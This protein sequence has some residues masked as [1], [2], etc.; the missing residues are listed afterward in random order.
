MSEDALQI[1]L[2]LAERIGANLMRKWD[3]REPDARVVGS[4]RRKSEQVHDI[5]LLA[6]LPI[7]ANG[8]EGDD[9]L[10]KKITSGF[11]LPKEPAVPLFQSEAVAEQAWQNGKMLTICAPMFKACSLAVRVSPTHFTSPKADPLG[12]LVKGYCELLG[13]DSFY[14]PLQIFRYT[15]GVQGNRGWIELMRTGS[16]DFSKAVLECWKWVCGTKGTSAPGSADGFLVDSLGNRRFTRNEYQVFQLIGCVWVAPEKRT[17]P[18]ALC[19]AIEPRN[20]ERTAKA[21]EY[22]GY[23]DEKALQDAYI[24]DKFA[25]GAAS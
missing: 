5:E 20:S 17:G 16:A 10:C 25:A 14:L 19:R 7:K 4:V 2:E 21:M 12:E 9:R 8:M 15:P 24:Q 11:A 3:L 23:K 13:E 1:P 22:L 6:P 18:E